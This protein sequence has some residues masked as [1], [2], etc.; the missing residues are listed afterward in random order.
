[1]EFLIS[2]YDNALIYYPN[3]FFTVLFFI[4]ILG[5]ISGSIG[6]IILWGGIRRLIGKIKNDLKQIRRKEEKRIS[7]VQMTRIFFEK[8]KISFVCL[9]KFLTISF[10]HMVIVAFIRINAALGYIESQAKKIIKKIEKEILI[11]E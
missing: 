9:I 8:K 7:L 1:M 3:V 11:E 6:I 5:I 4:S 2:F 10:A